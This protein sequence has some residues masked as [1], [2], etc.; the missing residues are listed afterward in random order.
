VS[1]RT[2]LSRLSP[3]YAGWGNIWVRFQTDYKRETGQPLMKGDE[4]EGVEESAFDSAAPETLRGREPDHLSAGDFREDRLAGLVRRAI[5]AGEISLGRGA[6]VLGLS[7][8][9]MRALSASWVG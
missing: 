9:E 4:P 7:L 8:I 2:V 5:E 6:E 1:Y 3:S